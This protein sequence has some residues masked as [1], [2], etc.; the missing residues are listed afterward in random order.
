[1]KER[2]AGADMSSS[3]LTRLR[4]DRSCGVLSLPSTS[5]GPDVYVFV[6]MV[7]PSAVLPVDVAAPSSSLLGAGLSTLAE[8][9]ATVVVG[10]AV[11]VAERAPRAFACAAAGPSRRLESKIARVARFIEAP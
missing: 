3:S 10:A 6:L 4:K 5:M 1:M 7:L 2:P 8:R 9:S 11:G